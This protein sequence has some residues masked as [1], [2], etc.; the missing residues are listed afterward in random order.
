MTH[1][2]AFI[3]SSKMASWIADKLADKDYIIKTQGFQIQM[4]VFHY[5]SEFPARIFYIHESL[6]TPT[7]NPLN[8]KNTA[9]SEKMVLQIWTK[10]WVNSINSLPSVY[11]PAKSFVMKSQ[12]YAALSSYVGVIGLRG[13]GNIT[14]H[15]VYQYREYIKQVTDIKLIWFYLVSA[16]PV[17]FLS[18]L[19]KLHRFLK[20]G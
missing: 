20:R 6:F 14:R 4:A 5:L 17:S 9:C 16:I 7:P 13:S 15:K 1:Y 12:P 10:C 11:D 3:I 2:G 19:M 18:P 8:V